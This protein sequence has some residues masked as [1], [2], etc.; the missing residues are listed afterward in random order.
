M[1]TEESQRINHF[2]NF[3]I[4]QIIFILSSEEADERKY[5]KQD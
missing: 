3:K 2:G 4:V 5:Q 1:S